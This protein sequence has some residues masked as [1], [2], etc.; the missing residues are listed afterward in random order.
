MLNSTA[1]GRSRSI[2]LVEDNELNQRVA[3]TMLQ[4]MGHTL[5]IAATGYRALELFGKKNYD[6]VFIDI[7]LPDIDGVMV[8]ERMR[9]Q[10]K[11]TSRKHTPIVAMTAHVRE[12]DKTNCLRAG[13]D[14]FLSKP[15]MM[16]TLKTT[17]E[18]A[19]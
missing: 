6:L 19:S 2:L 18:T 14:D 7:G 16:N 17:L 8:A 5:D 15:V 1:T 13:M 11:L 4:D 3:K 10:E 9:Q 12:E